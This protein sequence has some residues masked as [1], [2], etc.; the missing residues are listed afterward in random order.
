MIMSELMMNV[1][2]CVT[3]NTTRTIFSVRPMSDL[4]MNVHTCVTDNTTYT[5]LY[6]QSLCQI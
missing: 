5:M 3:D 4:M 2:A 1:H 6:V